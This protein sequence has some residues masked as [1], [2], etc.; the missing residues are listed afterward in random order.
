MTVNSHQ[1]AEPKAAEITITHGKWS[2]RIA[3]RGAALLQLSAG[4]TQIVSSAWPD[5]D[6]WFA[7]STLA[8]WVNRLDAGTWAHD[9]QTLHA[10]IND[11]DNNCA[12]HGLVFDNIFEV[13]QKSQSELELSTFI[14]DDAVYPFELRLSVF[15]ELT[16][17]G[18][19]SVI[20]AENIGTSNAP[21]AAGTH[22][23]FVTDPASVL[24]LDAYEEFEVDERMLPTGKTLATK[25]GSEARSIRLNESE[26]FTDTCFG[27]LTRYAEGFAQCAITRPLTN[28][29]VVVFQN[30][31]FSY[32]QVFTLMG[33][34]FAGGNTLVALEPQSAP[35]NAFN[36]GDGLV[37]LEPGQTWSGTWGVDI[38]EVSE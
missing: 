38:E 11:K 7:G 36:T 19:R 28:Q 26:D 24:T 5:S 17:Y 18:L 15:Y 25:Q 30:Q 35:A 13:V 37:W 21:F 14:N 8:P 1:S 3:L 6:D 12:N 16:E 31:E 33:T 34:D 22:P 9:G 20:S 27:G 4:E 32:L 23:Y 10:P 2:A 29:R